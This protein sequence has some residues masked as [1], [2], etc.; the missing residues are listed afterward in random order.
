MIYRFIPL[1]SMLL[2]SLISNFIILLEFY[3]AVNGSAFWVLYYLYVFYLNQIII[4]VLQSIY[5][6]ILLLFCIP[7]FI[8]LL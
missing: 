1:F 2:A 6:L 4:A 8:F 7:S 3:M 5:E